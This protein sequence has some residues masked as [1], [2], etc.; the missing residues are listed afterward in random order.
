M[1]TEHHRRDPGPAVSPQNGVS[2]RAEHLGFVLG[3]ATSIGRLR[4]HRRRVGVVLERGDRPVEQTTEG[5]A[6]RLPPVLGQVT[7]RAQRERLPADLERLGPLDDGTGGLLVA[8]PEPRQ[9]DPLVVGQALAPREDATPPGSA[10]TAGI[11]TRSRDLH[12]RAT[13]YPDPVQPRDEEPVTFSVQGPVLGAGLA[14]RGTRSAPPIPATRS[15]PMT[16]SPRVLAAG[17]LAALLAAAAARP[18]TAQAE[19][20]SPRPNFVL[21]LADDQSWDGLSVRMHPERDDSRSPIHRTP[22]LE[23]LAA[24]GLRCSAAYAPA[25]VCSP[26]R[27]A[28]QTGRTPA[29]LGWTKAAKSVDASANTRLLPP[30]NARRLA[31]SERTLG[32]LLQADG[33][34]TAHFGKWHLRSGGPGAHGYDVHDGDLGN[35]AAARFTDPNPVDLFGMA[36]RAAAFMADC[37][38]A[39]QPFF[40]QLSWHALHAP[41]NALTSTTERYRERM[42]RA[43]AK[44]IGRAALTEDLDTAVGRVLDA[45]DSLGLADQTFVVYTSDNGGGGGDRA[46]RGGKGSL[47]EGGIRVPLLVRGPGVPAGAWCHEPVSGI[48]LLPTFAAL[49]GAT[50]LPKEVEGGD[51]TALLRGASDAEVARPH[52]GLLFHFPHYQSNDGPESALRLDRF[53]IVRH[54]ESGQDAL[55]DL[56]AD[57]HEARDLAASQ[58]EELAR[59]TGLLDAALERTDAALPRPNPEFD[60]AADPPARR[61]GA[62]RRR[63]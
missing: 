40:A 23:E 43:N 2:D 56:E 60:P 21:M 36:E 14:G 59:M 4:A 52:P 30:A 15:N 25:P 20:A 46:M 54:Y 32:E 12:G 44:A 18:A 24:A 62:G 57:P 58:P 39:E 16:R 27:I 6:E 35:E 34:R 61:S 37:R 42:P 53:K 48:D 9:G 28:I 13:T 5:R 8:T 45:L 7:E 19:S 31:D 3:P 63:R 26:T 55:Y 10:N 11:T 38:K 50:E 47:S 22:R 1:T 51:L 49:A 29:A 17:L 41:E 33:Y